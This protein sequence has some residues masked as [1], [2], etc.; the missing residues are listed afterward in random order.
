MPHRL[1]GRATT[2][3]S[4][5]RL[6]P[7]QENKKLSYRS[8]D[9]SSAS[10]FRLIIKIIMPLTGSWIFL[11]FSYT[12]RV[13]FLRHLHGNGWMRVCKNSIDSTLWRLVTACVQCVSTT[14]SVIGVG[15]TLAVYVLLWR[16]VCTVSQ[17]HIPAHVG[18]CENVDGH[19]MAS[20]TSN[21]RTN[22]Y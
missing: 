5:K 8:E 9:R 4:V 16:A 13:G 21:I 15:V 14:L 18:W 17:Q 20:C 11:E 1:C 19:L 12:L 7:R 2:V 6:A 3:S 22:N 10:C